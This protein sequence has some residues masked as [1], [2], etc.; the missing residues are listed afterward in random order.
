MKLLILYRPESEHSTDVETFVQ[1]FQ[2]QHDLGHK[3][4]LLSV[5]SRDGAAT[6]SIYDVMS[7]PSILVLGDDG[8][9]LNMWQG[10]PLPLMNDVMG[11]LYA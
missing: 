2:R 6:A 7:Y 9:V 11:Y 3:L 1:D 8:S 10:L 4:E 5:N